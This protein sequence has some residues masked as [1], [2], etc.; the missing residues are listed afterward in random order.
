MALTAKTEAKKISD[1]SINLLFNIEFCSF[2]YRFFH[3]TFEAF[4]E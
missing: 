4:D 1:Y 3:L 2:L